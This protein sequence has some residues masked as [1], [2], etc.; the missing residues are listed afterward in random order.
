MMLG[1]RSVVKSTKGW[2]SS[3]SGPPS[4]ILY[5]SS[6]SISKARGAPQWAHVESTL[7]ERGSPRNRPC[8]KGVAIASIA[9]A[10]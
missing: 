5:V 6:L 2:K 9:Q 3:G 8:T 10:A 7:T 1:S 4:R